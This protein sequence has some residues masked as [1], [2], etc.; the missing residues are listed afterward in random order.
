MH[1]KAKRKK[2]TCASSARFFGPTP[3][4]ASVTFSLRSF[5]L[6]SLVAIINYAATS[7]LTSSHPALL[8]K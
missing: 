3:A 2:K 8:R 4:S 6:R 1:R 5:S 7:H